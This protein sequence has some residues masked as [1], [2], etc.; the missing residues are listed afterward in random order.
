MRRLATRATLIATIKACRELVVDTAI[1]MMMAV[2][3]DVVADSSSMLI[4]PV[5]EIAACR[6][7]KSCMSSGIRVAKISKRVAHIM[8]LL[9]I[10]GL[11]LGKCSV[12]T[13]I[14]ALMMMGSRWLHQVSF[15]KSCMSSGTQVVKTGKRVAHV[16]HFRGKRVV[17][18]LHLLHIRGMLLGKST[19]V[20]RII[21]LMM[22]GSRW[23]RQVFFRIMNVAR[24]WSIQHDFFRQTMHE[25]LQP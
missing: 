14:L 12:L 24:L 4:T 7:H 1:M 2:A 13:R 18:V 11:L 9:H 16:L 17:H 20:T 21:V 6:V 5:L 15:H 10:R 25:Y 8:H 19:L 3:V 22:M 23:L